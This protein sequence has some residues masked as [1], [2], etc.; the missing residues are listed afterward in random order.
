M[1]VYHQ[2]HDFFEDWQ[3]CRGVLQEVGVR[4]VEHMAPVLFLFL[5]SAFADSL[6]VEAKDY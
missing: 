3:E 6:E 5:M 2:P 1:N 4:Q